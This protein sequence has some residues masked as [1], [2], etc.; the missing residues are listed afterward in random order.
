MI[1]EIQGVTA[2]LAR[3]SLDAYSMRHSV[4]AQNIANANTDGYV[5]LRLNFEEQLKQLSMASNSGA[6]DRQLGALVSQVHP[7]AELR[8]NEGA[9]S[10]PSL[11]ID[12][13]IALLAQNTLQYEALLTAVGR[14]AAL[15]RTAITGEP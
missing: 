15:M 13:E 12:D 9:L 10:D 8:A 14:Q 3:M 1:N 2:Q 5:P 4:L 7:Y 6:S 11:R